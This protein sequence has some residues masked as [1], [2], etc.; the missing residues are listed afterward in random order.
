MESEGGDSMVRVRE[1]RRGGLK[2]ALQGEAREK[3]GS[4]AEA[5]QKKTEKYSLRKEKKE[6]QRLNAREQM[7][8]IMKQKWLVLALASG[9]F[10]ALNGLFAKL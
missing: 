3:G 8:G 4:G 1:R 7:M 9:T 6:I 2:Q 10:A 5:D